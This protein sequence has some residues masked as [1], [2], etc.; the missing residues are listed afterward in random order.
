MPKKCQKSCIIFKTPKLAVMNQ[1][2][3]DS[4]FTKF[5]VPNYLKILLYIICVGDKKRMV[6]CLSS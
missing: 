2:N 1:N 3:V 6:W 5:F 4:S